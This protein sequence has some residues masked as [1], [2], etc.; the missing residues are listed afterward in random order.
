MPLFL[1]SQ[2]FSIKNAL[3]TKICQAHWH[4][5]SQSTFSGRAVYHLTLA[6]LGAVPVLGQF[7]SLVESVA[8]SFFLKQTS[9][10]AAEGQADLQEKD[11]KNFKF[12]IWIK[13]M[14]FQAIDVQ[15]P[16]EFCE[17]IN[18]L[19]EALMVQGLWLDRVTL[20]IDPRRSVLQGFHDSLG[21]IHR[22]KSCLANVFGINI[23]LADCPIRQVLED[24]EKYVDKNMHILG[25]PNLNETLQ[26]ETLKLECYDFFQENP[27]T[28]ICV[29]KIM[30]IYQKLMWTHISTCRKYHTINR[31]ESLFPL[32]SLGI[33]CQKTIKEIVNFHGSAIVSSKEFKTPPLNVESPSYSNCFLNSTSFF[34][35]PNQ[36]SIIFKSKNI[37][38]TDN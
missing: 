23:S 10:L 34:D 4:E 30:E 6:F 17:N 26:S 3:F 1:N 25:I 9:Q 14:G 32:Q 13:N 22:A 20:Q 19:Y 2:D 11:V 7:I 31:L 35:S 8:A 12:G 16:E 24:I 15:S 21:I 37:Y 18:M 29:M 33:E 5:F 28:L 36:Q 27:K 38:F